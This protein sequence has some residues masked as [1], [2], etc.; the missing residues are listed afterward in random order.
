MRQPKKHA[1]DFERIK[2]YDEWIP[3]VIEE[4]KLE[5][6]RATGWKDEE[7]GEEK[8][9]D[10]VR[11]K[12]SMEGYQYP[13][14]SRWMTYSFAEKANLYKK[15]LQHL[16]EGAHPDMEFDLDLLKGF[17]IK[18]MWT[19]NGDYDN[20]EQIRPAGAKFPSQDVSK[21]SSKKKAEAPDPADDIPAVNSEDLPF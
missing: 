19:Q 1:G 17:K 2:Q 12:F 20:L 21:A 11:F 18:T 5:E 13:H 3:G 16:I 14:Y 9:A 4:I 10:M 7:T 6:E 15:Y 8:Y